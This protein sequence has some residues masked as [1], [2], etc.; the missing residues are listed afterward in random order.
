LLALLV[1]L[2]AATLS[3]TVVVAR[4]MQASCQKPASPGKTDERLP[5]GGQDRSFVLIVPAGYD[6][7]TPAPLVIS[8]HGFASNPAQQA[9]FAGW[10]RIAGREPVIIAY[11]MGTGF[12]ARWYAGTTAFTGAEIVND[13]QFTS[14]LID[15]LAHR[16]CIDDTRIFVNG[17]SNGGGMS[18]RVGCELSLRIAAIGTVAGAYPPLDSP[19][20]PAR[21]MPVIAFHGDTDPIVPYQGD[22]RLK[23]PDIQSWAAAWARRN[24]CHVGPTAIL[25]SQE[26]NGVAWSDCAGNADTILYTI[27]GGGHTWPGGDNSV[28]PAFL[29]GRAS[30]AIDATA[31]MWEFFKGHPMPPRP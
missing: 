19:C 3:Q 9:Q 24:G 16:L 12:P 29:V 23:T 25:T 28:A 17:L 4:P 22:A 18:N 7:Q 8:F 6:G 1:T 10:E 21:P 15:A 26:V 27:V 5:S 14:D 31:V 13:V 2:I 11:P 30:M 20:D